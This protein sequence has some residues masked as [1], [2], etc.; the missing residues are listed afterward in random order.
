M[1]A[2]APRPHRQSLTT[3][4]HRPLRSSCERI[5]LND[6]RA[7]TRAHRPL[8]SSCER[9]VLDD[10]RANTRAHRPRRSSRERIVLIDGR[11]SPRTNRQPRRSSVRAHRRHRA[12]LE[13]A[14]AS[15]RCSLHDPLAR[16]G[17]LGRRSL[18]HVTS[19]PPTARASTLAARITRLADLV[20]GLSRRTG[21]RRTSLPRCMASAS[22]TS[23][24][25]SRSGHKS[26]ELVRRPRLGHKSGEPMRCT[27]DNLADSSPPRPLPTRVPQQRQA[28]SSPRT[29]RHIGPRS[30]PTPSRWHAS[31]RARGHLL[32]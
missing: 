3:S 14:S 17:P 18:G 13:R 7:S 32:L 16:H 24:R 23:G 26:D 21:S 20:Y 8:R 6:S 10:S 12:S 9:I 30:D 29:G 22:G 5:V 27:R 25:R 15:R 2:R 4:A 1:R 11:S 31:G 28:D 19:S